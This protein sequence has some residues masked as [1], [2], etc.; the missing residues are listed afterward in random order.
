MTR[1]STQA[2][3]YISHLRHLL[4]VGIQAL[5][6]HL[7]HALLPSI[8]CEHS[9]ISHQKISS[10][11]I[12]GWFGMY[13]HAVRCLHALIDRRTDDNRD[14]HEQVY[15]GGEH[16]AKFSH[17]LLGGA[18]AFEGMKLFEDR[19]RREGTRFDLPSSHN[20]AFH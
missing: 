20:A 17:E 5:I 7:P 3:V 18:A 9:I 6:F 2:E 10:A 15:G 12:M 11:V 8:V 1:L 19:Q 4:A 14:A 13:W 16:E